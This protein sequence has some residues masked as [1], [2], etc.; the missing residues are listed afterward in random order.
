[1]EET[2]CKSARRAS[3]SSKAEKSNVRSILAGAV[4]LSD[5]VWKLAITGGLFYWLFHQELIRL[6]N[7]WGSANESHGMLIP[8]FSIYFI[9][10][11]RDRLGQVRGKGNY[12]GLL[13]IFLSL[14]V[15]LYSVY[16]KFGYPKPVMMISLLGGIVLFLGGWPIVRIVWLPV[17]FL[18]F[19]IPLPTFLHEGMTLPMRKLASAVAALVL[20]FIPSVTCESTGVIIHGLHH[21]TEKLDLNVAEACSGMRL[22]RVFVALGVAMAY[23]EYRP[24]VH[25]I[26]LVLSTVPIAIICNILRVL[27]T[28]LIYIYIGLE[29]AQG[30]LHT[31]LGMVMLLVAFG[32]YG[33]LAWVM[34]N[35]FV[36]EK[37][38]GGDVLIVRTKK[39]E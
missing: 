34:N 12:L 24:I 30:I 2:G 17:L 16:A 15:Y 14:A 3:E 10:Q 35:L 6:V 26:G 18:F 8:A 19:A 22:L 21:Y 38:E 32:L 37:E 36:E 1:M 5:R 39:G 28:G 11:Q 25:R 29:Y 20:N 4:P 9:Y 13:V 33:F 31:I 7:R 27:L 23:L